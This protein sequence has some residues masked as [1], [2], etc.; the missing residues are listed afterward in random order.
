M[1]V[2][3]QLGY[4]YS[5][6]GVIGIMLSKII[7]DG[8]NLSLEE[9]TGIATYARNLSHCLKALGNNVDI[10]Y[11]A[12]VSRNPLLGEIAFFDPPK[13]PGRWK[14]LL[15]QLNNPITKKA[16]LIANSGAVIQDHFQSRLPS[17][18]NLWS[19]PNLF[20]MAY[21]FF[22]YT[23]LFLKVAVNSNPEIAHWTYPLPIKI[24][25]AK[26]I[27]TIHDLIPLRLPY[28]TLDNKN[29]YFRLVTALA[30]QADHIVTVSETSKKDIVSLLG[31]PEEKIT[32]TY[33]SVNIPS[34]Y[35]NKSVEIV[36]REVEGIYNLIYK[37]YMLFFGAI[38]PKKN[39][40]RL[41]DSYLASNISTPLVFVGKKAW[42]NQSPKEKV[43]KYLREID[44]RL[45][46]SQKI[47]YF[48]YVQFSHLISLIKGAKAVFFPSLYEG[49]GL[50][51]LEAMQLGTPVLD[52]TEGAMPEICGSAS[53]LVNPYDTHAM[54]DAIIAL[55][56]NVD[57]RGDLMDKGT[58]QAARFSQDAYC[59]RL[60]ELYAGLK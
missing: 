18:D 30:K 8:Y 57:L 13:K 48:D 39:V 26:N 35:A 4:K 19:V 22:D 3:R 6:Y 12:N 14:S 37:E 59:S 42:L 56:K 21:N 58:K 9:G 43:L 24:K 53:L 5:F 7:I 38:E 55:D 60:K 40:S 50:P 17:A 54:S 27:Y 47:Y 33:Q 51:A 23:K 15:G 20:H 52:S 29:R 45:A 16:R 44:E 2:F 46:R 49:F 41:I 32:N 34:Q 11:G 1:R 36:K 28:T 25:N 31:I 10:L